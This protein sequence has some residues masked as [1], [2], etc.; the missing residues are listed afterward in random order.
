[1]VGTVKIRFSS[2]SA[3]EGSSSTGC[4]AV[5]DAPC[6]STAYL[7]VYGHCG[8]RPIYEARRRR[9]VKPSPTAS[10]NQIR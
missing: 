10:G 9:G 1:M 7:S 3:K 5:A 2:V 6:L 8:R 4:N